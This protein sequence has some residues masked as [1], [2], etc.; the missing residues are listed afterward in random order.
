[1]AA[2]IDHVRVVH[3]CTLL[4]S[5]LAHLCVVCTRSAENVPCREGNQQVYAAHDG[6]KYL[7][8]TGASAWPVISPPDSKKALSARSKSPFALETYN[9]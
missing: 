5:G 6:K 1:M 2:L 8:E 3:V 4:I 7:P 9:E